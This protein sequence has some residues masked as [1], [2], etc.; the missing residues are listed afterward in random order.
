M[1]TPPVKLPPGKVPPISSGFTPFILEFCIH[2]WLGIIVV[3]VDGEWEVVWDV[4]VEY[5]VEWD[6]V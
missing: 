5:D 1:R 2:S 3:G 6:E 4:E